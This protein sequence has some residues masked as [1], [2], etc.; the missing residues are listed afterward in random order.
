MT[1]LEKLSQVNEETITPERFLTDVLADSIGVG[2]SDW[3]DGIDYDPKLELSFPPQFDDEVCY[4]ERLAENARRGT[5]FFWVDTDGHGARKYK[6]DW[7]AWL[8]LL[9]S[10]ADEL[11]E[12]PL[13]GC[14]WALRNYLDGYNDSVDADAILQFWLLGEVVFG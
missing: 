13:K 9:E 4:E 3:F 10:D 7:K 6:A 2:Y 8:C 14:G 5:L 1:F 11:D 12:G